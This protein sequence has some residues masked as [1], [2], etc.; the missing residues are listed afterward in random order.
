MCKGKGVGNYYFFFCLNFF[1]FFTRL[2]VWGQPVSEHARMDEWL[3]SCPCVSALYVCRY[4]PARHKAL[5]SPGTVLGSADVFLFYHPPLERCSLRFR[6][7]VL[8]TFNL[9]CCFLL[10]FFKETISSSKP[11]FDFHVEQAHV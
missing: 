6:E 1:F 11:C 5:S 10:I 3:A 9:L 8:L 7:F 2:Q 4:S